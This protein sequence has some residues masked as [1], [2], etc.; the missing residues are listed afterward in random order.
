M[1]I[2]HS[3]PSCDLRHASTSAHIDA[4]MHKYDWSHIMCNRAHLGGR[5]TWPTYKSFFPF[6]SPLSHLSPAFLSNTISLPLHLHDQQ[7]SPIT[8]HSHCWPP[9]TVVGHYTTAPHF[10][11]FLFSTITLYPTLTLTT[12]HKFF[13]SM[14]LTTA[15]YLYRL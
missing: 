7:P 2:D 12:L 4:L 15:I 11:F 10:H 5:V 14:F 6:S 9:H 8:T 1:A 3:L 13:Y